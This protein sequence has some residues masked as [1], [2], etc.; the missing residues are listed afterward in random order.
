MLLEE[1][2]KHF[3]IILVAFS[4]SSCC[5]RWHLKGITDLDVALSENYF[6][7]AY[8]LVEE[9]RMYI[10][11]ENI[12]TGEWSKY[13]L[14]EKLVGRKKII[15]CVQTTKIGT[16]HL[17]SLEE[18]KFFI[19]YYFPK[20]RG[21]MFFDAKRGE[22]FNKNEELSIPFISYPGG[23]AAATI[24]LQVIAYEYE[25]EEYLYFRY[26][27]LFFYNNYPYNFT[28]IPHPDFLEDKIVDVKMDVLEKRYI[29]LL[30]ETEDGFYLYYIDSND[31]KGGIKELYK[32]EFKPYEIENVFLCNNRVL[33]Y[34][35]NLLNSFFFPS[36]ITVELEFSC[37]DPQ[38]GER[39]IMGLFCYNEDFELVV[40]ED[41]PY[42][43]AN[44]EWTRLWLIPKEH[45]SKE[46]GIKDLKEGRLLY[47]EPYPSDPDEEYPFSSFTSASNKKDYGIGILRPYFLKE[48]IIGNAEIVY[49]N[50]DKNLRDR[51]ALYP[52]E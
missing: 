34:G 43:G 39:K 32:F 16:I 33:F 20:K 10:M 51:K 6:C 52:E 50:T 28:D 19:F 46:C 22:S 18:D 31:F 37:K 45:I 36:P 3:F 12:H 5:D 30:I 42:Y 17:Q 21:F 24:P 44:R 48:D 27:L 11:C 13:N 9:D 1:S 26:N 8:H 14:I 29:I 40:K 38:I 4:F 35:K 15:I 23:R 25:K 41:F 49:I 7:G 47:D 2:K